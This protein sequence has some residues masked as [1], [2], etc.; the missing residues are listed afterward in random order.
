[1]Q[2]SV[3]VAPSLRAPAQQLWRTGLVALQH[4]GS[5]DR[6]RTCVSCIAS[7]FI[8]TEPHGKPEANSC[9]NGL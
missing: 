7:E 8:I 1:M 4:V 5:Q 2:G 6:D 9:S 3:V